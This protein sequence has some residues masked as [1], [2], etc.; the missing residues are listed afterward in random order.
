MQAA[1]IT[2]GSG[3]PAG[4]DGY[5]WNMELDSSDNDSATFQGTVGSWSWEDASLGLGNGIGWRHQSDWIA[6]SLP[7]AA[8]L[9]VEM[10]R[11]DEAIDDKLFPSFTLYR[12][13]TSVTSSHFFEN[14]QTLSWDPTIIYEGHLANTSLGAAATT[15]ELPAG[16]YTLVLGGNALSEATAVNVDYLTNLSTT[17]SSIPEPTTSLFAL[18]AG[19][20]F[21]TR[22]SR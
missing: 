5:T 21:L 14:S 18:I 3:N 4:G 16:N 15:F 13:F 1:I 20:G 2:P 9:F 22:R 10:A 8:K 12:N 17:P 19:L 7:N 6:I 11:N